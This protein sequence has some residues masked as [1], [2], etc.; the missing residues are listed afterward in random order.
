VVVARPACAWGCRAALESGRRVA[1]A[2]KET[3][4]TGGTGDRV[5]DARAE[6]DPLDGCA[7][8]SELSAIWQCLVGE[9]SPASASVL[10]AAGGHPR[11]RSLTDGR[12]AERRSPSEWRM[13]PKI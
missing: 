1:L 13:G 8:R 9:P 12:D 10:T 3:R 6:A 4:V 7:D 5:L 2:N 11:P